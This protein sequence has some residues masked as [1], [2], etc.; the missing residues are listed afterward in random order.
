MSAV[1]IHGMAN[2]GRP[3]GRAPRTDTPA[4]VP[5]SSTPTTTVAPTTAIRM[6]GKRLLPLS[7]RMTARVPAPTM[8]VVQWVLPSITAV[9]MALRFPN[10]PS[11]SIEK[12]NSLGSWLINTVSA[13]PFM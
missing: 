8:N 11:L 1:V 7:S 9:A 6:P 4:C 3:C 12:P 13:M 10:G 5:R 2:A